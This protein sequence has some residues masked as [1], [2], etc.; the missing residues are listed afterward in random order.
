MILKREKMA[1]AHQTWLL[2][3]HDDLEQPVGESERLPEL[4]VEEE[5][6][7]ENMEHVE[8]MDCEVKVDEEPDTRENEE[9]QDEEDEEQEGEADEQQVIG[10]TTG[11]VDE[12]TNQH[13]K[14]ELGDQQTA[15][16]ESSVAPMESVI[17]SNSVE[18]KDPKQNADS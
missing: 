8:S 2:I 14:Q 16:N 3:E 15:T 11:S 4:G 18:E 5:I 7:T 13:E 9:P 12:E 17:G 10:E 1:P 6:Q